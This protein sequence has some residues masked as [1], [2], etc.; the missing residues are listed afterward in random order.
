[1][2]GDSGD[3]VCP[4]LFQ[5]KWASGCKAE[6]TDGAGRPGLWTVTTCTGGQ[7]RFTQHQHLEADAWV[8]EDVLSLLQPL[9]SFSKSVVLCLPYIS[10]KQKTH[11][12]NP[13]PQQMCYRRPWAKKRTLPATRKI[14]RAAHLHF[15]Q[16][17]TLCSFHLR[18][19][20]VS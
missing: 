15:D 18:Q 14:P 17:P 9:P 19:F 20:V 13:P 4:K 16:H 3:G 2:S 10:P 7:C 5:G 11:L 6:G 12:E 1:M 8:P